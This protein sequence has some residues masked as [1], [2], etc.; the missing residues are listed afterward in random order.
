MIT[1]IIVYL[2]YLLVG[3]VYTLKT[4]PMDYQIVVMFLILVHIWPLTALMRILF[5]RF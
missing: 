5:Y 3:V 1:P 2:I 4:K